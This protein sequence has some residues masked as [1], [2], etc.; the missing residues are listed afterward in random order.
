M[1]GTILQY[2]VVGAFKLV[3]R[4]SEITPEEHTANLRWL[5][6]RAA[7]KPEPEKRP[8]KPKP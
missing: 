3:K 8:V 5:A 4:V 6:E 1:I 2:L 7:R